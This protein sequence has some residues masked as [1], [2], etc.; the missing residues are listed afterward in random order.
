MHIKK[1]VQ[2]KNLQPRQR[3]QTVPV[4]NNPRIEGF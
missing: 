1:S 2:A 3:N 4:L